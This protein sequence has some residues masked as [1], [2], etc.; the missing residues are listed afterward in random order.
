MENYFVIRDKVAQRDVNLQRR[1]SVRGA[2]IAPLLSGTRCLLLIALLI[3]LC[4]AS[5]RM[6]EHAI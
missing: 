5:V 4:L 2:N 1:A 3:N 6:P